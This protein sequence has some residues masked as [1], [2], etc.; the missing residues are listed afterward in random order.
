MRAD[1]VIDRRQHHVGPDLRAQVADRQSVRARDRREQ[2]VAGKVEQRALD[3]RW[4]VD[5]PLG[6]RPPRCRRARPQQTL[7]ERVVDR[8]KELRQIEPQ[9]PAV[10]P[11]QLGGGAQA[12]VGAEALAARVGLRRERTLDRGQRRRDEQVLDDA[13]T[14]RQRR[15]QAQLRLADEEAAGRARPPRPGAK[16]R[17]QRQAVALAIEQERGHVRTS[18]FAARGDVRRA[19][20]RREIEVDHGG[21]RSC[22]RAEHR[23]DRTEPTKVERSSMAA[24][25]GM[26]RRQPSRP[27]AISC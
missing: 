9:H 14:E 20:Y 23:D 3:V 8:R 10:T 27:R 6:D 17:D 18:A 4:R 13:I 25:S 19:Q 5:D 12:A 26:R 15:D 1:Q 21:S 16:L 11:R 7:D 24:H 22:H 2:I